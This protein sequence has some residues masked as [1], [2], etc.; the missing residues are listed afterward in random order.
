[1]QGT[2]GS[3]KGV[4]GLLVDAVFCLA[5]MVF[6]LCLGM[7]RYRNGIDLSDE[8]FLA[9]GA[10]R[11]MEGQTPNRDFV[12]LQP[13]LSFYT[14]A[15]MFS[16][17]GTSLVSLRLLGLVI[18]LLIPLL[19]YVISRNLTGPLPSLAAAALTATF[20][21]SLFLYVPYAV[22]QG[23]TVSAA[24]ALCFLRT[25]ISGRRYWAFLGGLGTAGVLL[26][27]HDQGFYMGVSALAGFFFV[28]FA[29]R[30]SRMNP[31]PFLLAMFWACGILAVL[32]PLTVYW[33]AC[34][35]LPSMFG[36]LIVFPLTTYGK[37]SSLPFPRFAVGRGLEQNVITGLFYLPA[38]TL[39]LA[40]IWLV[41][42]MICRRFFHAHARIGFLLVWAALF[43]CQVLTRSDLHHLVITFPPFFILCACCIFAAVAAVG[44]L[45]GWVSD[46]WWVAPTVKAA[47]WAMVGVL[48]GGAVV[49]C[50]PLFWPSHTEAFKTLRIERGGVRLAAPHAESLDGFLGTIKE[51]TPP[52]RPILC[53]PYQPM[54]YFLC[55]RRNP[56]RWNYLWP[57]D[58]TPDEHQALIRQAQ[59]DPPSVI[60]LFDEPDMRNY[61]SPIINYVHHAF[62]RA[63]EFDGLFIYLP[64]K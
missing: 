20:G 35:A 9:Y 44:R 13:P 58:Q 57:G 40:F 8:G 54:V 30:D 46:R 33:F 29:G 45:A 39:A 23:I 43:Y 42:R 36:Q 34:G 24:T 15:G 3:G 22:W 62:R 5:I 53:L 38:V 11:V 61:A 51:Q 4:R 10:V 49:A 17:F 56:T 16:L 6:C 28:W 59:E 63:Y 48:V 27:R 19:T 32:V 18:S 2:T 14:V 60:L 47:M 26:L 21:I 64:R 31:D 7:S 52:D 37:T 1:M 25:I 41:R 50:K 55:E 12:S